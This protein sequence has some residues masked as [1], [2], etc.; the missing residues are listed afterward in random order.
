M[1]RITMKKALIGSIT[2]SLML[3]FTASAF[4]DSVVQVWACQLNDGKT[5]D[6]LVA[7]SAAWLKAAKGIEGGGDLQASLEF[8]IAASAGDGQFNFV[9][10]AADTKTWGLFNNDYADSPA[11]E[12]D[13]AWSEVATCTGSD[14]WRSVDIE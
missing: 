13:E 14:L 7:V 3:L 6:E 10:I 12:A 8:P 1:R 2:A 11:G 5:T 9:L 4:A